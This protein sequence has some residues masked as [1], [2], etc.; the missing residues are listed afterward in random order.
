MSNFESRNILRSSREGGPRRLPEETLAGIESL[1]TKNMEPLDPE[2]IG[3]SM[4]VTPEEIA[5]DMEYV[6]TTGERIQ[7]SNELA[8]AIAERQ[9]ELGENPR[10]ISRYYERFGHAFEGFLYTNISES[11]IFRDVILHKTSTFD[12]LKN[13]VDFVAEYQN[14]D[15]PKTYIALAMDAS[16]SMSQA[17]IDKKIDRSLK[18]IGSR[19]LST[20][21]Y[22]Q[23]EEGSPEAKLGM[24]RVVVGTDEDRARS[25]LQ[26]WYTKETTDIPVSFEDDPVWTLMALQINEQLKMFTAEASA[27][28]QKELMAICGKY[29]R[30][31]EVSLRLHKDL[32][33]KHQLVMAADG[34][35]QVIKNYCTKI[36]RELV[37][38]QTLHKEALQARR[39]DESY[40]AGL[41]A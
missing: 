31:L 21:K 38:S 28:G 11:K 29:Q 41:R 17:L 1:I 16:F 37:K 6:R 18:D 34:T 19:K 8:Q 7:R 5:A 36:A 35:S 40:H 13:G 4:G 30:A 24:P 26:R 22:F 3:E 15:D 14:P 25:L 20:V 2:D 9:K 39:D 12:D 27:H 10:T 33:E 23:Y 32:V